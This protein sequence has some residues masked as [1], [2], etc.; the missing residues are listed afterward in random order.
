MWQ[1]DVLSIVRKAILS[2]QNFGI[3]IIL[4]IAVIVFLIIYTISK[5]KNE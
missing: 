2:S 5:N 3:L 1:I 4:M